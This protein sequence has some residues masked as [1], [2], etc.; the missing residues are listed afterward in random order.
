MFNVRGV[1]LGGNGF[2][3]ADLALSAGLLAKVATARYTCE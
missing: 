2:A 3:A 1:K